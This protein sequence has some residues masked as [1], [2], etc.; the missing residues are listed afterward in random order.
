MLAQLAAFIH[1]YE[2]MIG[3]IGAAAGSHF[4]SRHCYDLHASILFAAGRLHFRLK[5]VVA[6]G[7]MH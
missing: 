6:C 7:V 4:R 1:S 3:F 2:G 5:F